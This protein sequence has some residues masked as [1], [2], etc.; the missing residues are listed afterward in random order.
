M[1]VLCSRFLAVAMCSLAAPVAAQTPPAI[2]VVVKP[3]AANE[4]GRFLA[5]FTR[6]GDA[7]KT[8][9]V[10][11]AV[12]GAVDAADFGRTSLPAGT[13]NFKAGQ[14]QKGFW[15]QT[16]DDA[17]TE[18]DEFFDVTLSSP[19]NGTI[20]TGSARA[21]IKNN[22]VAGK[23]PLTLVNPSQAAWW[24]REDAFINHIV[25]TGKD[26]NLWVNNGLLDPVA[27]RFVKT[28]Q[29][30]GIRIG[31]VRSGFV[32]GAGDYYK[33]K[34]ILDW[35]GDGDLTITGGAGAMT[36]VSANRIEE[37]Y[38]PAL[39]G[40]NAPIVRITRIGAAGVSN[41]RYYR[42]E[43]EP[44]LAAGKIFDPRWLADM[45]R[46]DVIRPMDWTGVKS[47]LELTAADRPRAN[48]SF[49]EPNRVPD[50]VIV[51][52]AVETGTELWLNAPPLLGSPKSVQ[53]TLRDRTLPTSTRAA[54]A[55]AAF[56]QVM[57]S[58]EPLNWARNI[59]AEMIA[60]GYPVD[61]RI[62]IELGNEVWNTNYTVPTFF[63]EGIGLEVAARHPGLAGTTRT[64]YGYRSAQYAEVFAQA[65]REAGRAQ[66]PWTV[67]LGAHTLSTKRTVEALEGVQAYA[68]P[69]P[70]SRYGVAT[71]NYFSDGFRWHVDNNLFGVRL[72]NAEWSQ[73][74]LAE[75]QADR[76]ALYQRITAYLLSPT[77]E[78][79]NVAFYAS[80]VRSQKAAAESFGARWIG[81][82]EGDSGER[83]DAA[84]TKDPGA[85][86][87]F[88]EWHESD[89]Y[90]RVIT[91]IAD[92]TRAI[93]P[94]AI[95][96]NYVF[97]AARRTPDSPWVEC[98]PW[99]QSGGDNAAWDA[100][101][102]PKSP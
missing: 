75:L 29:N 22:D 9:S 76:N 55:Q 44:L 54:A 96:A 80:N 2:S 33:G 61:R 57:A 48:R 47:G 30:T 42:A 50:A 46:F 65:L 82:F 10:R 74:W 94:T 95:M 97:C 20:A 21:T 35:Q 16:A 26:Y 27:A 24:A 81:N 32:P 3:V 53:T 17:A 101:L 79:S 36:R 62:I 39:H 78:R 4:G 88:K 45:A 37:D 100:L 43:H 68:G 66:Q 56:D 23:T 99:D 1:K 86:A 52:A 90:G 12:S 70:M 28:P 85:V 64:G 19:V 98:T 73:R 72:S 69:E 60:A 59:V 83:L 13:I 84:L 77:K 92:T 18:P 93:D 40:I 31:A 38:D 102:K 5:T 25:L 15:L 7:S 49:Y 87:L 6:A 34:W 11:W 71:T 89:D 51:R 91:A 14:T 63:Y 58:P 8:S 41:I 67:A